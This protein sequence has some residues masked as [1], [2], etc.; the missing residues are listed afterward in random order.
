MNSNSSNITLIVIIAVSALVVLIIFGILLSKFVFQKNKI[1]RQIRDLDRRFQYLHALLI[2]QDAQYVKR[3]EIISRTNLLYVDI[4]TKYLKLFKEIRDKHDAHAQSTINNLKDLNEEKRFKQ[5]KE[6]IPEAKDVISSFEKRVNDLNNELL[7]VVKPEEDCR[8]SSLVYKEKLRHIKSEYAAQQNDLLLL[9]DSFEAVFKYIDELFEQFEEF[10]ENA[11]YD[12]ANAILPKIDQILH[13]VSSALPDLANLCTLVVSIIPD[14]FISLEN[15]YQEMS[16]DNYPLSH[17]NVKSS[18]RSM[19]NDLDRLTTRIKRFDLKDV[20]LELDNIVSHIDE[21]FVRF[22][23]EKEAKEKFL[24]N[25]EGVYSTV[26]LI[27]R[28][29]IKLCNTIP[30][31]NKIYVINETNRDKINE[32][33]T[34]INKV[35]ALKRSLDTFIHSSTKQPY[36]IL[37]QKM[38]ELS[39]ASQSIIS[40]ISDFNDYLLSLKNDADKAFDSINELFLCA[41]KSESLLKEMNIPELNEKYCPFID[42]FYELLNEVNALLHS[43]PIDV[44]KVNACVNELNEIKEANFDD[45]SIGQDYNMMVLAKN[46]LLYAN[47]ARLSF[48]DINQILTQAELSFSQGDFENAYILAGDAL[49]RVKKQ[50]ENR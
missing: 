11:Q 3:L 32:I 33:Q 43:T 10:V 4:H 40:E 14:K 21:F 34:E 1:R 29:F 36:S 47:R 18:I 6:S 46:A 35:G 8:Q 28:K 15:A 12:D 50:N 38:E 37:V 13:E 2:G 24:E 27:E 48:A 17:L 49:Q 16:A 20:H 42:R 9:N 31:V 25:N 30:E 39:N 44:E 41:K 19:K 23:E 5:L 45:G 7:K 26:N 22:S